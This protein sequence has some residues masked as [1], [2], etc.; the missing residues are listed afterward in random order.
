MFSWPSDE[1]DYNKAALNH[2]TAFEVAIVNAIAEQGTIGLLTAGLRG[3]LA[4]DKCV[5]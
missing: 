1:Y 5:F 3:A 2:C 4:V